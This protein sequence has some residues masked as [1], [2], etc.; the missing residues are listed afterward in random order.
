LTSSEG[1]DLLDVVEGDVD[2]LHVLLTAG[3]LRVH[4]APQLHQKAGTYITNTGY[5]K[6][7]N[8]NAQF[9]ET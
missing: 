9:H 7:A 8:V 6:V 5:W 4:L 3:Q 1:V 2:L